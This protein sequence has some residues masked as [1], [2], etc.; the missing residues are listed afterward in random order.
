MK[1]ST[2]KSY[3]VKVIENTNIYYK[4]GSLIDKKVYKCLQNTVWHH[5]PLTVQLKAVC[6]LMTVKS[7]K[8]LVCK[9]VQLGLWTSVLYDWSQ[10]RPEDQHGHLHYCENHKTDWA[11]RAVTFKEISQAYGPSL[12]YGFLSNPFLI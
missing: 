3:T 1:L 6:Q 8:H 9:A 4:C 12:F 11:H 5:S 7:L 2:Y 10:L